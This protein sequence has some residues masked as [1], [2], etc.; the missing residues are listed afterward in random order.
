[1]TMYFLNYQSDDLQP[2]L[3][4]YDYGISLIL[5]PMTE[6]MGMGF[7]SSFRKHSTLCLEYRDRQG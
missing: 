3:Y 2:N 5:A 7:K 4:V 6:D 1:M